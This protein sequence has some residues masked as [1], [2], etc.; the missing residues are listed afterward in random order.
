MRGA[1][2]ARGE[3]MARR[4]KVLLID[5][6]PEIIETVKFLL[7]LKNFEVV[8][9][10]DGVEGLEKAKSEKPDLILLDLILPKLNG[11]EVCARLKRDPD[12]KDIPVLIL[13]AR[14]EAESILR[15]YRA[16]AD[17][18]IVKPFTTTVLLEKINK[19][20]PAAKGSTA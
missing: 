7:G 12:T 16:G 8:A 19:H 9:A 20:L 1:E 2:A 18:Y 3:E 13:T 10:M 4:R 5:D 15:A 6:E 14:D 11:Y 17:E